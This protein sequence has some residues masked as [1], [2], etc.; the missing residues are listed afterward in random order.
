MT[1]QLA[2]PAIPPDPRLA[3]FAPLQARLESQ[4]TVFGTAA[5]LMSYSHVYPPVGGALAGGKG[6]SFIPVTLHKSQ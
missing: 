1:R 6:E 4:L 3:R 2:T 5:R